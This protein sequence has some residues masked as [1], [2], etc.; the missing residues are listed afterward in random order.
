MS[1]PDEFKSFRREIKGIDPRTKVNKSLKEY[2][3]AKMKKI[4][5]DDLEEDENLPG[6]YNKPCISCGSTQVELY[7]SGHCGLCG[8]NGEFFLLP[9]NYDKIEEMLESAEADCDDWNN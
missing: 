3:R 5:P 9:D 1:K 8:P 6:I 2:N 7:V 4:N